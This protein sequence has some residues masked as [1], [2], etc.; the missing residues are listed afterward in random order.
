[1]LEVES[2]ETLH[3]LQPHTKRVARKTQ[4]MNTRRLF[5][6][7]HINAGIRKR[8]LNSGHISNAVSMDLPCQTFN[9]VLPI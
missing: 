3:V 4:E 8:A 2:C 6:R 9:E 1:M 5:L 7:S